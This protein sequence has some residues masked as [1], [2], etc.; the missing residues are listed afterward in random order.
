MVPSNS[1]P[2]KQQ[3]QTKQIGLPH[4]LYKQKIENIWKE[5]TQQLNKTKQLQSTL[6]KADDKD[7]QP[8][9]RILPKRDKEV[10]LVGYSNPEMAS[11]KKYRPTQA[12]VVLESSCLQF[13]P[14][15][16]A[17]YE[18]PSINQIWRKLAVGHQEFHNS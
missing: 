8:Q 14:G 12:N 9:P 6:R 10:P 18:K 5:K 2:G 16:R 17:F 13:Q 7:Q 4:E 1:H 11:S 15:I 3:T